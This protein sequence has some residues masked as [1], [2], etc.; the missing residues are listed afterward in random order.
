M[1]RYDG[2]TYNTSE[3]LPDNSE[4]VLGYYNGGNWLSA[5]TRHGNHNWCVVKF[6]Q[7]KTAKEVKK[8]CGLGTPRNERQ[9][10]RAE[11][12]EGNNQEPYNWIPFG[13]G[14]HFGQDITKWCYLPPHQQED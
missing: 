4:W 5:G 11:D 8:C 6:V 2:I 7:G 10:I 14:Q 1:N 12:Q 9:S 3:Y 13:V